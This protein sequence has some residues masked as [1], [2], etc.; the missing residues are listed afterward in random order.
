V[1]L[2][3]ADL[4]ADGRLVVTGGSDA[5][6][7][8]FSADGRLLKILGRRGSGPGEFQVPLSP[9]FGPDGRIHVLDFRHNG[10]PCFTRVEAWTAR[11]G[12]AAWLG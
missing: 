1:N 10:S 7:Q 9:R 4:A 2:S 8:L 3:G 5:S 12:C 6:A 11:Y